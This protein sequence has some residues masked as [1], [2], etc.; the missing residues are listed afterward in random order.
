MNRLIEEE[1][2]AENISTEK[3]QKKWKFILKYTISF[4]VPFVGFIMGALLL[5]KDEKENRSRGK[6]YIFLGLIHIC[7]ALMLA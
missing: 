4:I 7:I 3:V 2:K 6:I 1:I 5:S